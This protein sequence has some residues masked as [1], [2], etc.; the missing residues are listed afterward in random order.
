[1]IYFV[2]GLL[3]GTSQSVVFSWCFSAANAVWHQMRKQHKML[4]ISVFDSGASSKH[5]HYC[6]YFNGLHHKICMQDRKENI[7][8]EVHWIAFTN[9]ASIA[10]EEQCSQSHTLPLNTGLFLSIHW[11]KFHLKHF[12]GKH[13]HSNIQRVVSSLFSSLQ[14]FFSAE[15][16]PWMFWTWPQHCWWT[17]SISV[18]ELWLHLGLS[19]GLHPELLQDKIFWTTSSMG[20]FENY[21]NLVQLESCQ[22][23]LNKNQETAFTPIYCM[24]HISDS[25]LDVMKRKW[26][27]FVAFTW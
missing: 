5:G 22:V 8:I 15:K 20:S 2:L 11:A 4:P 1:M 25:R 10:Y 24:Q 21:H 7:F 26:W 18:V 16:T 12:L 14:A 27:L 3:E 6:L 13:V 19:C 17:D 23:T 9:L